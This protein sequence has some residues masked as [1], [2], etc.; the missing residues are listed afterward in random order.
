MAN[1]DKRIT[2]IKKM[3]MAAA[4][5]ALILIKYLPISAGFDMRASP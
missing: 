3:M 5:V 2:T 4:L 1:M